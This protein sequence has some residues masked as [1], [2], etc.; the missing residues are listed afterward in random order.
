MELI[1]E[2]AIVKGISKLKA[3]IN[4]KWTNMFNIISYGSTLFFFSI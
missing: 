1:K 2:N 3:E 4:L